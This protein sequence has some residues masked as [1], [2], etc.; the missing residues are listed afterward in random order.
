M[1]C[2]QEGDLQMPEIEETTPQRTSSTDRMRA[3]LTTDVTVTLPGWTLAL[4]GAVA[5][6]L[7]LVALD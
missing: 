4:G 7:V 2:H 3:W 6:A 1:K 5:L